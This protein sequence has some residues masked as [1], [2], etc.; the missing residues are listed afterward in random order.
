MSYKIIN[1]AATI[2]MLCLIGVSGIKA[3][4]ANPKF[5]EKGVCYSV[6]TLKREAIVTHQKESLAS[7]APSYNIVPKEVIIQEK[8]TYNGKEYIV[9]GI[10]DYSFR[11]CDAVESV[12]IPSTVKTIG[13]LAFY[14]TGITEISIPG[15]V[16]SIGKS[17]FAGSQTLKKIT[18]EDGDKD[19]YVDN[20]PN[21]A[22]GSVYKSFDVTNLEEVYL[23]RNIKYAVNNN[24]VFP[25]QIGKYY[26]Y[27]VFYGATKLSTVTIGDGC[28]EILDYLFYQATNITSVSMS[29]V[30]NIRSNA[31]KGCS[32]LAS[33]KFGESLDSIGSGAFYECSRITRLSFPNSLKSIGDQCFFW[34]TGISEATFGSGLNSISSFAFYH[35]YNLTAIILPDGFEYMGGCAFEGCSRLTVAKLGK[36]LTAVPGSAFKDCKALSEIIL[37]STVKSVGGSA[38]CNDAGIA[39][40]RLNDGL[41]SIGSGAFK[42]C[43][44]LN[45][46]EIPGSVTSMGSGCFDGC[47]SIAYLIFKQG[48]DVLKIDNSNGS[49]ATAYFQDCPVR[50]LT[51]GRDLTYET[52]PISMY[53]NSTEIDPAQ[54]IG[55]FTNMSSIISVSLGSN[56]SYLYHNLFSGC[57]GIKKLTL[58]SG[59]QKVYSG[60]LSNCT[61]IEELVFPA[62]LDL[63]DNY[64]CYG[65]SSLVSVVFE[66]SDDP[67][68]E[69]PIGMSAFQNCVKLSSMVFPRKVIQLGKTCFKND[70]QITDLVFNDGDK[71]LSIDNT[72]TRSM[73]SDCKLTRLYIGRSIYYD[74]TK[75]SFSPFSGQTKLSDIEF[76]Q[77][78][79][80]TRCG[81]Y[82]LRGVSACDS[83]LLPSSV[84]TLGRYAFADMTSLKQINIPPHVSVLQYGLFKNDGMISAVVISPKIS[85]IYD[86]VFDGCVSL[87]DVRFEDSSASVTL[88]YGSEGGQF[89]SSQLEK[90]HL[91]RNIVYNSTEKYGYSPFY[92]QE[93]LTE[94]TFNQNGF[95]TSCGDYFLYG[96]SSCRELILPE[97]LK[98]IGVNAFRNMTNLE[99]IVIPNNVTSVGQYAFAADSAMVS[100]KLSESCRILESGLFHDCK[101]LREIV[102]PQMV[103]SIKDLAFS[104]CRSLSTVNLAN[105]ASM[106]KMGNGKT[107][108]Q[109]Q[110]CPIETLHVGRQINYVKSPFMGITE[111]KN[112]TF[113]PDVPSVGSSMFRETGLEELYLPDNIESIG[114][115]GFY[116]CTLLKS[117]RFGDNT[118]Q[119][120]DYG[121]ASCTSLDNVSFPESM[122]SISSYSFSNCTS[123]RN[124]DLGKSLMIIGPSAFQNDTLLGAIELPESLYG[125]GVAS[126]SG[127]KSI[128][129]IEINGVSSVGKQAFQG[130]TG[131]EWVSLNDKMTSLGED[132]F[133]GCTGIKYVKSY[134]EYPPEGLVNFPEGVVANGTLYVP[135][136]SVDYY[137][138]SPTWE[139]WFA[140][141]PLDELMGID[142][143]NT[144]DEDFDVFINGNEI[145]LTNLPENARCRV[146]DMNGKLLKQFAVSGP[147]AESIRLEKGI[148][149]IVVNRSV[150]KILVR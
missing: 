49:K 102:V 14:G 149:I 51:L 80:V 121:F 41:E 71:N 91:G 110:G 106:L 140:I 19:I 142:D 73:F 25:N 131:L 111:L 66:D 146:Y 108:G 116:K 50:F 135:G 90:L 72:D 55:P 32:S 42:N 104:G 12:S 6:D 85:R 145:N 94:I 79:T 136:M 44:G 109:F 45:R 112:L 137:Q 119:I 18:F 27:S 125:L 105:G 2:L 68:L 132:S 38:F 114:N 147:E 11:Y 62:G 31:F 99:S 15:S 60:A 58:P 23:G 10:D 93:N 21:G 98:T 96:A 100:V 1:S 122:T 17:A 83:L 138:Y 34:C 24:Y 28:T 9:V 95:V 22:L 5:T 130:C 63:V 148:Y 69:M 40:C 139:N 97:S 124:L 33:V 76:S 7:T 144:D 150:K 120:G 118:Y 4:A 78:G 134:A 86:Y 43:T 128:P 101:S 126:F 30:K 70:K 88:G 8:I 48:N 113:G 117:V 61:G 141:K 20:T 103:D 46:M 107:S 115:S 64:A 26:D 56:V 39:L 74:T 127:C 53:P 13:E 75:N 67:E 87:K 47:T 37:P 57:T 92:N 59:L 29:N 36:S 89:S 65:D 3:S 16:E 81:D 123:L 143:V 84:T 52:T 54:A 35:C 77:G 82:F 133:S 129:Y